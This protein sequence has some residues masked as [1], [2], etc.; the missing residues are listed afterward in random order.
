MQFFFTLCRIKVAFTL[1]FKMFGVSNVFFFFFF[2]WKKL[3]L[4]F[5]RGIVNIEAYFRH[6][7]KNKKGNWLF[8]SQFWLFFLQLRV[9]ISQFLLAWYKLTIASYKVWIV[10]YKLATVRNSQ[11]CEKVYFFLTMRVYISVL[12]KKVTIASL[13]HAILRKVTIV[14]D[15]LAILRKKSELWVISHNSFSELFKERFLFSQLWVYITQYWLYNSQL[16]VYITQF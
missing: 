15:K 14:R 8:I 12:K 11:N 4:L 16:L 13:Y 9:Y 5:S 10:V 7:I 1:S 2:F 6:W 3:I